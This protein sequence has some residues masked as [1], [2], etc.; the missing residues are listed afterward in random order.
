MKFVN[1]KKEKK[2]ID[3][4]KDLSKNKLFTSCIFG[5]R[6]VGKT[7]LILESIKENDLYFFVNKDKQSESLL[8][9]YEEYLRNKKI[10]NEFESLNTWEEFFRILFDRYKGI[11]TFDEFQNFIYVN[12]SVFGILQKNI[13]LNENKKGILIIFSGSIIG[14]IKKIFFNNGEPLYGRLKRKL[15]LKPL[16]FLDVFHMCREE[17]DIRNIE[18]IINLYSVFGGFPRYYVSIEDENLKGKGHDE[19]FDRFFF[20]ENALFEDEVN[21]ILSLEFGKR[22]GIYYDI[23]T[24]IANGNTRISEISSYLRK[25][26]NLL[27]RQLDELKN[28]FNFISVR[29]QIFGKKTLM[30]IEHPLMNFW[31][32]FFYKN[33]SMYKRRE[34]FLMDKIKKDLK[35]LVSRRFEKIIEEILINLKLCPFEFSS[36][37]N[38]WGKF[39]GEIGRNTYE[40]DTIALNKKENKILFV[41]CKWERNVNAS[42]VLKDL[43]KKAEYV[44]WKKDK[45]IEYYMIFAKSFKGKINLFEG[46]EVYCFDLKD[47][48]KKLI[49]CFKQ[50]F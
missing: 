50:R 14:L 27:T 16:S 39:R 36:I 7:R 47:L 38:Q 22:K 25:K 31:F 20:K 8:E 49:G 33:L 5:S 26:E 15:E 17:L 19:I 6:R 29:K 48:E 21:T 30:S 2:F 41:E 46:R 45:R 44:D 23:L 11:V 35:S 32:K 43:I 4:S 40:I 1:R 34:N 18:N 37:G 9:E 28:Y 24:A 13:D 10:L 42:N 3:E 12:K